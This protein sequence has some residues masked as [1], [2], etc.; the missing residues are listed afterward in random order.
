MFL[1]DPSVLT[2]MDSSWLQGTRQLHPKVVHVNGDRG[3]RDGYDL[4]RKTLLFNGLL[5]PT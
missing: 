5:F 4:C 3:R 1:L 2:C